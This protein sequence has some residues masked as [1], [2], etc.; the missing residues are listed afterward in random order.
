MEV[1]KKIINKLI[2]KMVLTFISYCEKHNKIEHI[3]GH[4]STETYLL[5]YQVVKSRYFNFYIH[6][7][8][9]SDYDVPHD[10][11][12]DFFTY[13]VDGEYSECRYEKKNDG[14][15]LIC[16]IEERPKGAYAF[17]KAA[18]V[19]KLVVKK[20]RSV[21]EK[22]EAPLTLFI[23]GPHKRTWGFW[24]GDKK[25]N[26]HYRNTRFLAWKKYLKLE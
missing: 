3:T 17:R 16:T 20:N 21:V 13:M 23:T 6:R 11:P 19:H 24:P 12:W 9:R 8:L 14:S 1:L 7:V 2:H 22:E 18:D 26:G 15:E 10:H 4:G 5:R 25:E